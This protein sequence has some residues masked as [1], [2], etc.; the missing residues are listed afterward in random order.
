MSTRLYYKEVKRY[1]KENIKLI[2]LISVVFSGLA[3]IFLRQFMGSNTAIEPVLEETHQDDLSIRNAE[4]RV[5]IE[6][7][8]DTVFININLLEKIF[9]KPDTLI[10]V[11]N[12]LGVDIQTVLD[13]QE[14]A[15]FF[16]TQSDRGAIGIGRDSHNDT[17][18]F[19]S[20]IGTEEERLSTANYFFEILTSADF[21]LMEGKKLI[22]IEKPHL[23]EY[24]D[25]EL[26]ASLVTEARGSFFLTLLI[27]G[28]LSIFIGI[29][30]GSI[31]PLFYHMNTS[32]IN[33][34][35]NYF[36]RPQDL[37]I[38]EREN[39]EAY[40]NIIKEPVAEIKVIISEH[41]PSEKLLAGIPNIVLISNDLL[42]VDSTIE[43]TEIVILIIEGETTK[44][45]YGSQINYV[46]RLNANVRVIQTSKNIFFD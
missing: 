40:R 9:F 23:R 38:I 10:E 31:I 11:N 17:L 14:D 44:E 16:G 28:I 3:F 18:V 12:Q 8:N 42:E 45:W 37:V 15:G 27:E 1:F 24:S 41:K 33:Y 34:G 7:P 35:F 22:V 25:L 36:V 39:K 6:N 20:K 46:K 2:V 4:F 30:L 5:Y 13:K 19:T 32:K 29:T 21:E 26:E 43:L